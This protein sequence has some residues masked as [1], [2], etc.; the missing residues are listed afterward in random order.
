MRQQVYISDFPED[1]KTYEEFSA[2]YRDRRSLCEPIECHHGPNCWVEIG[3]PACN[4][5]AN[6][7]PRCF[8]CN[9]KIRRLP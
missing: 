5:S 9:G 2:A 8:G 7:A 1:F 6:K 4:N 3:R